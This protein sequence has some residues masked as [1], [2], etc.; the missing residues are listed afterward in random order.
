M[1]C[2][3]VRKYICRCHNV[4]L[5]RRF[6][7]MQIF[8]KRYNEHFHPYKCKTT[9]TAFCTA[10]PRQRTL[11]RPYRTDYGYFTLCQEREIHEFPRKFLYSLRIN[12]GRDKQSVQRLTMGWT[13]RGSNPGGGEIFCTCPDWPWGTQP[14]IQWVPGLSWG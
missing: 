7:L 5:R 11:I 1:L 2:V 4:Q 12:V 9:Y 6:C 8:Y 14:P 10:L 3:M 13:V